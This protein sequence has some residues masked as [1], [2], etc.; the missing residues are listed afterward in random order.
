MAT[1]VFGPWAKGVVNTIDTL[2]PDMLARAEN[3]DIDSLG[4]LTTRRTF[5]VLP[6]SALTDPVRSFV[7][8]GG[9]PI[10][11][12]TGDIVTDNRY[13]ILNGQFVGAD[14]SG[15]PNSPTSVETDDDRYLTRLPGGRFIE[16][17]QGRLLV[18]RG[19]SLL[20]SEPMLYGAY[21]PMR[22]FVQFPQ[23]IT[24]LA[25]LPNAVFVGT[26]SLVYSL[27][28]TKPMDWVMKVVDGPSWVGAGGVVKSL[29]ALAVQG[30]A[31]RLACWFTSR[32]F[33]FGYPNGDIKAPQEETIT[34]LPV[35]SGRLLEYNDR[36]W[37]LPL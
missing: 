9:T 35:D 20:Y 24:W 33:V 26:K 27:V 25:A 16:A 8:V 6:S 18:A 2:G 31:E 23:Q 29:Q 12:V 7:V 22:N 14:M 21:D 17:W 37:V 11:T 3:V 30:T 28:G 19:T 1:A 10:D 4:I 32:G 36:L 13:T 15:V 34:G 5:T